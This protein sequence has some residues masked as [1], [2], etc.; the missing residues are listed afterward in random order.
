MAIK[1]LLGTTHQPEQNPS[2]D[3]QS[4]AT[5]ISK[6]VDQVKSLLALG[7]LAIE[8][9]QLLNTLNTETKDTDLSVKEP[10]KEKSEIFY[11]WKDKHGFWH[12]SQTKPVNKEYIIMKVGEGPILPSTKE[13][14]EAD[15][16]PVTKENDTAPSLMSKLAV[17]LEQVKKSRDTTKQ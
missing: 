3:Q 1:F 4:P 11:R 10:E 9:K 15:S 12:F 16:T 13:T 7:K 5:I 6:Q 8:N 14:Q 17:L 2:A